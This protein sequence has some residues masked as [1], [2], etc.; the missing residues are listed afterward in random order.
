M[1]SSDLLMNLANGLSI[2]FIFSKNQLL[3]LLTFATVS[4]IP[5]SFISDLIFM[6]FSL[7]LTLGF[8]CSSFSNCF[9]CKVRLVPI[10][11][12]G[13]KAESAGASLPSFSTSLRV[14]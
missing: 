3:F 13:S 4:F 14:G 11:Q 10:L 1:C 6:I 9:R 8:F 2:L 5:F 12:T 7:Q